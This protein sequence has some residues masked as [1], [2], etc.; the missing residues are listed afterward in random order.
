MTVRLDTSNKGRSI[1]THI[2]TRRMTVQ[3]VCRKCGE[4]FQLTSS[5]GG[6]PTICLDDMT[7]EHFN[8]HPHEE[9]D[10]K[11]WYICCI[12]NISTHILTRRMTTWLW[13]IFLQV[14]YFNS[15]PH[16]EDDYMTMAKMGYHLVFQLT[17][18]RG[19]WQLCRYVCMVEQNISTHIL[20][21]RMTKFLQKRIDE[22]RFQLTSSRGGW[23]QETV[24]KRCT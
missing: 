14:K 9:D 22:H 15:H 17:S 21:R 23:Q 24:S 7:D 6:W 8:S 18:S 13:R 16:E 4:V 2:L 10:I 20:T 1:S 19:G 11:N 5:R 12:C 3:R